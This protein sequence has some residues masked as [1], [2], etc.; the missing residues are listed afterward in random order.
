MDTQKN[1]TIEATKITSHFE[2]VGLEPILMHS[3]F[4]NSTLLMK[5]R[6]VYVE[7]G[8]TEEM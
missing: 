1:Q 5:N 3:F 4:A 6:S 8:S 7:G 2:N